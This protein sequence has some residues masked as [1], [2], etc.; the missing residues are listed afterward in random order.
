M[1]RF[2]KW[3]L[4]AL[5]VAEIVLVRFGLLELRT[6]I[7]VVAGIEVLLLIVGF[8][9]VMVAVRRY[10]R[11]RSAGFDGWTAL[12]NGLE[13]I[14]PRQ[15]ARAVALEPKLWYCLG[16]WLLRRTRPRENEFTYHRKSLLGPLLIVLLFTTPVEVLLIHLFLPW[17]WLRWLLLALA[18]YAFLWVCGLYASLV[19]LPHTLR[20][21]GLRLAYGILARGNI[22]YGD[23]TEAAVNRRLARGDGL[24]VMPKED[25]AYLS[26]GGSTDVTLR[27]RAPQVMQGWLG[28]T[29]PVSVVHLAADEP[30]RLVGELGRK[31]QV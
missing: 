22:D 31:M 17:A 12:E 5:I 11:D 3:L 6:A 25:A 19:V 26:V 20:D 27:L 9:Q 24:R 18:V 4:L 13:V 23:I 21:N 1:K 2:W 15:A 28:P 30:E 7:G 8:R 10:R 29:A 14:L 16:R